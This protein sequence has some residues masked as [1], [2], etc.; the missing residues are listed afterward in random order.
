MT[1]KS[2]HSL[3]QD[4]SPIPWPLERWD[5]KVL[6]RC[7]ADYPGGK[8]SGKTVSA[9]PGRQNLNKRNQ[10]FYLSLYWSWMTEILNLIQVIWFDLIWIMNNNMHVSLEMFYIPN[11]SPRDICIQNRHLRPHKAVTNTVYS[12]RPPSPYLPS[13]WFAVDPT[14]PVWQAGEGLSIGFELCSAE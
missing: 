9:D 7:L 11:H 2:C 12:I 1:I 6:S 10:R 8:G 14:S 13:L 3:N 5:L 4:Q